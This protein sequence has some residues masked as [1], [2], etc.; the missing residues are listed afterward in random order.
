MRTLLSALILL[1]LAVPAWAQGQPSEPPTPPPPPPPTAP[2][3]TPPAPSPAAPAAPKQQG[4]LFYGGGIG[5]AFGDIRYVELSPMVGWRFTQQF[6]VGGSLMYRWREDTRWP[7]SPSYNDWGGTLFARY[8]LPGPL[9]LQGEY[10]YTNYEYQVT[11][12][13]T[14]HKGYSAFLAGFGYG[15]SI[16]RGAGAY[17]LVLYDFAY[18]SDDPYQPYS[19]PWIVRVGVSVGF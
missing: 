12:T 14:E 15:G 5:L 17:F 4:Q 7:D 16:G 3:V 11:R 13:T 6:G 10:D 2:S 1:G 18:D 8:R 9:F 19:S